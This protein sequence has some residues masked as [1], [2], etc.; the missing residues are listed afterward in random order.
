MRIHPSRLSGAARASIALASCVGLAMSLA[1][2]IPSSPD[3]RAASASSADDRAASASPPDG[4]AV[5][6]SGPLA[7]HPRVDFG[8][9]AR[10]GGTLRTDEGCVRIVVGDESEMVPSFPP[11][12][13]SFADGVLTWRGDEYRDGDE[14]S[15]GG[16][17]ASDVAGYVPEECGDREVFIVSPL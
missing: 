5:P 13:A 9:D 11:G 6:A 15:L 12:D 1:A 8:M 17:L 14:I 7:V 10:L 4:G 16:G 2:C 3:D